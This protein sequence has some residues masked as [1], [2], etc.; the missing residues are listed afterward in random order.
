MTRNSHLKHMILRFPT[1]ILFAV[2]LIATSLTVPVSAGGPGSLAPA[3]ILWREVPGHFTLSPDG[4]NLVYIKS[5]GTD[6]AP[7]LNNGTLMFISVRTKAGTAISGADESV[8]SYA[9]SPDGY[10]VAY[11]AVPRER[12]DAAVYLAR[13]AEKKTT[14][15]PGATDELAAGFAWLGRDRLV[16]LGAPEDAGPTPGAADVVVVDERPDPVV[17]KTYSI[18]DGTIAPLSS[19]TDVI[20]IWAPSPD[21]RYILYKASPNPESWETGATFRYTVLDTETGQERELFTLIEGYQDTNQFAW[22]PD[23]TDVWIERMHNGGLRYPVEYT[24]DL[25]VYSPVTLT[26]EEVPLNWDRGLLID[27]FNS[28]IEVNPFNGGAYVLL[29]DGPNPKLARVKKNST[30]WQVTL[31]AGEHQG[32]IFAVEPD[33]TGTTI[34]YDYNSPES[35]PQFFRAAVRDGAIADTVQLTNLNPS[36]V[37]KDLGSSEVTQWKGARDDTV[38]GVVRYPPGYESGK[39]YPLVLVIHGGP[40]YVDFDS[41]RDT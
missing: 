4:A 35:P 28:D 31:L 22:S 8:T 3:D 2:L 15:L 27:L 38:V 26:L 40:T 10:S 5:V 34:V 16:F 39:E 9:L 41:W 13:L 36:L 29:A 11:V 1:C 12:G 18:K 30:G 24:S 6:L 17:L 20:T 7:P 33:R 25:L 32:N 19:N 21:G 37:A 23:S 14:R